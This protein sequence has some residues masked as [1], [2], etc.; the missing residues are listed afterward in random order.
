[1]H[2]IGEVHTNP[3]VGTV[4]HQFVDLRRAEMRAGSIAEASD[5][6]RQT[7]VWVHDLDMRGLIL[8]VLRARIVHIS[9]LINQ[10]PDIKTRRLMIPPVGRH[11]PDGPQ[12]QEVFANGTGPRR[13]PSRPHRQSA[14]QEAKEPAM[15]E[16]S[17][18]MA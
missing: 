3:P 14:E 12:S 11:F 16:C 9:Q 1:M 4:T 6:V 8:T 15:G 7:S 5:A 13:P 17:P 18:E 10:D 2:A